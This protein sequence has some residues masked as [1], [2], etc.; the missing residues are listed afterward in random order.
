MN[1]TFLRIGIDIGGT[2]TDFVVY[3]PVSRMLETFKLLSTPA[4]PAEAVLKGLQIIRGK[5]P[6]QDFHI[7]HGSTVATNALL[8]RSAPAPALVTTRGFADV[9]QI[10]RQNRP[11]L[12]D[13]FF[14][15]IP[16]LVPEHLRFEVDE[17]VDHEGN[18][19][20]ELNNDELDK[21]AGK[22]PSLNVKSAAVCLLFSFQHPK[23][24][25]A[26]ASKLR[27]KGILVSLSSEILPEFREYERMSTTAV[28]AYVSP[29]LEGYLN[30]LVQE[31]PIG[32]YLRVMQSNGGNIN[33]DE[34]RRFG[35]RCILSGPAGGV[36]GCDYVSR[37]ATDKA[38]PLEADDLTRIITFDM[39]GT[40]TD[41]SLID[42][43]PQITTEAVVA[44][45]PIRIP[46]MDIHTIGAGGGSIA[47]VDVGG[48]L[49]VGP[50]SAGADPGPACYGRGGE[51]PTVTDANLVLGRLQ[52]DYFLGGEMPLNENRAHAALEHLGT[53]LGLD[54]VKAALGVIQVANAHMER[55]LRV[56]SVER[57]NDPRRF[58]LLS[59]GGAGS[60][61]AADLARGLG[62]PRVLIPPLASTLSAFGM[63][64]ADVVKDYSQTIM[65]P[66]S[67]SLEELSSRF[68]PLIRR[69]KEE[70]LR[71]GVPEADLRIEPCL[72]MRYKGQSFEL[73]VP[74]GDAFIEDFHELHEKQ[75]GYARK[76]APVEIVNLR[77]RVL[78]KMEPPPIPKNDQEDPDPSPA[79]MESRQVIFNDGARATNLYRA[80][81]LKPG[82]R[83]IG[84]AVVIRSDTTILVCPDD[85]AIVDAW[86]NLIIE[87]TP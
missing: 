2:F 46:L 69:G 35:V 70:I 60:L 40:S 52:A 86:N 12:Y 16:P 85:C 10:G 73:I 27:E 24:E 14:E 11:A 82:N 81:K 57:G 77:L 34:A 36:V 51:Q 5:K 79:F 30:H 74:F 26:I 22:I 19:L 64:A 33:V 23:H 44:G 75:Y 49:Q 56:I 31:L 48:S 61:H 9:L 3:D 13:L 37:I 4:D 54:P 45:C 42:G 50:Q 66:G 59:F 18:V 53:E 78:G 21:L 76:E 29:V 6:S 58:N 47:R 84:P 71:E 1:P 68:E 41:V 55:A 80:E 63:L 65:L 15:P 67:T 72:D 39:G 83:I 62:I 28:N 8:E 43:K 38:I 25:Q 7:I 17:R 20:K 32:T 87:V